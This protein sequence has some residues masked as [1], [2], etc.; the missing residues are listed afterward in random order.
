MAKVLHLHGN[1]PHTQ[2]EMNRHKQKMML[3]EEAKKMAME[4]VP[5]LRAEQAHSRP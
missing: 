3:I 4:M 2:L 1:G 5:S